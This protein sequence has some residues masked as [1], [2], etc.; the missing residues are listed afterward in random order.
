MKHRITI[1]A[2]ALFAVAL[3]IAISADSPAKAHGAAPVAQAAP[4]ESPAQFSSDLNTYLTGLQSAVNTAKQNPQVAA[5][6]AKTGVDPAASLAAAQQQLPQLSTDDLNR[7]QTALNS[8]VP[9]WKQQAGLL[10]AAVNQANQP[11][12]S[13]PGPQVAPRGNLVPPTTGNHGDG[14]SD[15]H[16]DVSSGVD[17]RLSSALLLSLVGS[18]AGNGRFHA[19]ILNYPYSPNISGTFTS[20]CNSAGDPKGEFFALWQLTGVADVAIDTTY[21]VPSAISL[22]FLFFDVEIPDP[23]RI[24]FAAIGAAL[25]ATV[26]ALNQTEAVSYDCSGVSTQN[27]HKAALPVDEPCSFFTS[28]YNAAVALGSSDNVILGASE[29]EVCVIIASAGQTA[30]AVNALN[31][32][33]GNPSSPTASPTNLAFEAQTLTT[34][35]GNPASPTA[36]PPNLAY[37]VNAIN[38]I[39]GPVT[40]AGTIS[41][42]T[43]ALLT[44]L[45]TLNTTET[46]INGNMDTIITNLDSFQ[47]LELQ[48]NIERTLSQPGV[49][50]VA[51]FQLPHSVGGFLDPQLDPTVPCVKSVV[52][53]AITQAQTE[54]KNVNTANSQLTAANNALAAG[55]YKTAYSDYVKAYQ[56]AED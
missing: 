21:D 14:Q 35:L 7:L 52:T 30:N 38:N 45:N 53:T 55:Q 26:L 18:P 46:T 37:T 32:T 12:S 5:A 49:S 43:D 1:W 41:A 23:A 24:I 6:F 11:A 8:A 9:N 19:P 56:A 34:N 39:T 54:G 27:S 40:T 42:Q 50:P 13:R 31:S 15:T 51:L 10:Q 4:Q 22:P 29:A 48:A 2:A 16:L 47:K 3:S 28:Q 17:H 36:S 25:N 20:D 33:I 44:N